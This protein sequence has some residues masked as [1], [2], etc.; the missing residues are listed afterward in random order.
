MRVMH[1]SHTF[2]ARVVTTLGPARVD[3]LIRGHRLGSQIDPSEVHECWR[4]GNAEFPARWIQ[5]ER[6][7][8]VTLKLDTHGD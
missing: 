4:A 1:A 6:E 8:D 2:D 7:S 5:W 3:G